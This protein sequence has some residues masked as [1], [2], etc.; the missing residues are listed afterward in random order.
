MPH[1]C[2]FALSAACEWR[3]LQTE[4]IKTNIRIDGTINQDCPRA[5]HWFKRQDPAQTSLGTSH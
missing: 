3:P 4:R 2:G 5:D 1:S